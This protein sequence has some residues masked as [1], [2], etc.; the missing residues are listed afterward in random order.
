M[1]H[2]VQSAVELLAT[3]SW[4]WIVRRPLSEDASHLLAS[5]M[6]GEKLTKAKMKK[7]AELIAEL[8]RLGCITVQR[9]QKG[10]IKGAIKPKAVI[11]LADELDRRLNVW[12]AAEVPTSEH[13]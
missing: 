10:V 13:Q 5:L 12:I 2:T 1:S 11:A 6:K 7:D 3:P 9:P 8:R 4:Q